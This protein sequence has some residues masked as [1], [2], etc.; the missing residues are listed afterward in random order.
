M[1]VRI[2]GANLIGAT[3]LRRS[4]EAP[5]HAR[6]AVAWW[7]AADHPVLGDAQQVVTELVANACTHVEG[8]PHREWVTESIGRG[9]DCLRIEVADPGALA[10]E[11]HLPEN[12]ALDGESGR[13]MRIVQELSGGRWG[14][15]VTTAGHRVVWTDLGQPPVSDV[16]ASGLSGR[17]RR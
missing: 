3:R 6:A 13:G 5:R 7:L 4:L 2:E 9:V 8:G 11:P 17:W 10:S 14:T 12:L 16:G 15:Y 1:L